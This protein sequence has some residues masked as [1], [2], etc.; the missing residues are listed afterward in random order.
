M[1]EQLDGNEKVKVETSE[2]MFKREI[3]MEDMANA[4]PTGLKRPKKTKPPKN[5]RFLCDNSALIDGKS[6]NPI[7]V[8][9]VAKKISFFFLLFM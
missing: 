8:N 7:Y 9:F 3:K 6:P 1:N 2:A 4:L 5:K